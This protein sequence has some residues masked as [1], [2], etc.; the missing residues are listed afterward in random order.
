MRDGTLVVVLCW[1]AISSLLG[2]F[3][4]YS[5]LGLTTSTSLVAL[6]LGLVLAAVPLFFH[7]GG[8]KLEAPPIARHLIAIR[9][10]PSFFWYSL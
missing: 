7:R 2:V 4:G 1:I 3:F 8:A 6:S 9:S 5:S 10:F